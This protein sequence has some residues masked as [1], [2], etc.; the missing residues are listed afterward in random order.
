MKLVF[1]LAIDLHERIRD[2]LIHHVGKANAIK[3]PDIAEQIGIESGPSNITIRTLI[4][5]TIHRFRL[6][7]AGNPNSGYFFINTEAELRDYIA[8]MRHRIQR[9]EDRYIRV[10]MYF[11]PNAELEPNQQE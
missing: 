2:I 10:A 9:I 11:R 6:S 8:S 1:G 4:R 3:S 7:V 5:E